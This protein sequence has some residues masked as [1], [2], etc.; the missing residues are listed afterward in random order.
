MENKSKSLSGLKGFAIGSAIGATI[1][2]LMAPASGEETRRKI[3]T[4]VDDTRMKAMTAIEDV[5]SKA[6]DVQSKARNMVEEVKEDV[7]QRAIWL[8]HINHR[9]IGEQKAVL[10]Q[11]I[12]D[13][14]E[15][16][17]S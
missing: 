10:E 2:L 16:L 1:A 4:E 5:Q 6:H 17:E 7:Q 15:V 9:V 13:A 11:G 3:K 14:R 12:E 8:K